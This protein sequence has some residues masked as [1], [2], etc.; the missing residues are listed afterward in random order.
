LQEKLVRD[1]IPEIIRKRGEVPKV[2]VAQEHEV[3]YLI[4]RKVAE[5]AQELLQS[6]SLEE[7]ADI[8]EALEALLKHREIDWSAVE[9][10]RTRKK[11]ERGGFDKRFVLEMVD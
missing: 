10:I 11:D 5:E 8:L 1:R 9:E 2:R 3:D 7:I 4:R 6:S